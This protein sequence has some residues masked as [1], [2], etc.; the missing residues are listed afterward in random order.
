MPQEIKNASEFL[1]P[2]DSNRIYNLDTIKNDCKILNFAGCNTD[3][4]DLVIFNEIENEQLLYLKIN[5]LMLIIE[6]WVRKQAS[7]INFHI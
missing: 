5:N 7:D 6:K 3:Y 4:E 1:K 2:L